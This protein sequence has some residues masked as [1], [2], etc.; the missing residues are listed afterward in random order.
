[1]V[2]PLGITFPR[3]NYSTPPRVRVE[4]KDMLTVDPLETV[5]LNRPEIFTYVSTLL[6]SE[7]KEQLWYVLLG[8]TDVFT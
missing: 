6:S 5:A 1:M 3:S 8:N 7:E 4:K 2:F